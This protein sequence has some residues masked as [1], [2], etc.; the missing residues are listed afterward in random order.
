MASVRPTI[1][2]VAKRAGVSVGTV[3]NV[4]NGTT[5]VSEARQ[6][7]VRQAIEELSYS[8]NLMAQGLRR[9]RSPVI[10]LCV[11]HTSGAYFARLVDA[12]EAVA[13]RRHF[14]IMQ[15]LTHEDP[16]TEYQRVISLLNYRVGGLIL[17]PSLHPDKTLEAVARSGTPLVVVDRPVAA[18]RF[19][20]VTFD[21]RSA[22]REVARSLLSLGHRRILFAVRFS[23]L[24]S[25]RQRITALRAAARK[26]S[27]AATIGLLECGHDDDDTIIARVGAVLRG[28]R[29]PTAIIVSNS[30]FAACMLRAFETLGVR[31]PN[32]V[33]LLAFDQPEWADLVT[34]KLAVVRQ[35]TMEVARA[36]W[37]FLMRRMNDEAAPVQ[38]AELHAAVI[39][40]ASVAAPPVAQAREGHARTERPRSAKPAT[41]AA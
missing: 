30:M 39:L 20:Q 11:P 7:R 16:K 24:A 40:E 32:D 2:D 1:L 25:T 36:A 15:T 37:E 9:R 17:V 13:D 41:K 33:S 27:P 29:P 35:P 8:Q 22:M 26:A 31:C 5:N 14:E 21:N 3:S 6:H 18:G 28:P 12:F 23:R 4:L 10:G 34:P 38:T 19:D